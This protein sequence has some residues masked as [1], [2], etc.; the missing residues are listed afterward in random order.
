VIVDPSSTQPKRFDCVAGFS[1]ASVTFD[2]LPSSGVSIAF[3][4]RSFEDTPLYRGDLT[5]YPLPLAA[6]VVLYSYDRP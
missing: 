1:P 3:Q 2:A 4:A 6:D 5:L